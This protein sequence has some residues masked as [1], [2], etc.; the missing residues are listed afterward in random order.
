MQTYTEIQPKAFE[1]ISEILHKN[2]KDWSDSSVE[3]VTEEAETYLN[4]AITLYRCRENGSESDKIYNHRMT[5]ERFLEVAAACVAA[6]WLMEREESTSQFAESLSEM[7]DLIHQ[8][9]KDYK[10]KNIPKSVKVFKWDWQSKT[11]KC[12]TATGI[13]NRWGHIWVTTPEGSSQRPDDLY[14]M[15][16]SNVEAMNRIE[17]LEA[18][19][20]QERKK[21]TTFDKSYFEE[22]IPQE[23]SDVCCLGDD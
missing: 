8:E 21:L 9:D 17:E 3:D 6:V 22:K 18:E 10:D 16:P 4:W 20:E 11:F 15:T 1:Q 14:P 7:W 13:D 2:G 5:R 19:L 23:V 12:Y